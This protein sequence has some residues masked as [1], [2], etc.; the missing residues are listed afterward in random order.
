MSCAKLFQYLH[1][2][3]L[4][5]EAIHDTY[6]ENMSWGQGKLLVKT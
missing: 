5:R 3:K 2:E 1:L 6:L 4:Y